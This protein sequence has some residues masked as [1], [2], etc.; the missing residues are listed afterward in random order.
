TQHINAALVAKIF[1]GGDSI[2]YSTHFKNDFQNIDSTAQ[3]DYGVSAR[4]LYILG[5][6]QL[7]AEVFNHRQFIIQSN[8]PEFG[9][10]STE[11]GEGTSIAVITMLEQYCEYRFTYSSAVVTPPVEIYTYT[12]ACGS[13]ITL[14]SAAFFQ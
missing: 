12:A 5:M 6:A 10:P 4:A 9:L 13:A 3:T 1:N 14:P 7:D 8:E 2:V 11:G